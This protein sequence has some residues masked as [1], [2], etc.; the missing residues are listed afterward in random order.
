MLMLGIILN[1]ATIVL[2]IVQFS[3]QT[4]VAIGFITGGCIF[5]AV[6]LG[7]FQTYL[8]HSRLDR[9]NPRGKILNDMS[10]VFLLY[11]AVALIGLLFAALEVSL[12]GS[13]LFQG[14]FIFRLLLNLFAVRHLE[15]GMFAW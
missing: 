3:V 1:V 8:D 2:S 9:A 5:A 15:G 12:A 10:Y 11:T 13:W 6:M 7:Y 14:L 4:P